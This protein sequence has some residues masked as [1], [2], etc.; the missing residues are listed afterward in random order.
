MCHISNSVNSNTF[1]T[2]PGQ[3]KYDHVTQIK[4]KVKN[5]VEDHVTLSRVTLFIKKMQVRFLTG[6]SMFLV[7]T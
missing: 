6:G 5:I 3:T 1:I 2:H 4:F 7:I